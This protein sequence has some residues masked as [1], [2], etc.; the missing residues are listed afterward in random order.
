MTGQDLLPVSVLTGFLGSGK[1]T[2]LSQLL[3][4]AAMK[5]TAVI[6]NEFGEVGL[7]HELIEKS[8][9]DTILLSSGCLCCTIRGDLVTSL[10]DLFLRRVR[11]EVP[12]FK[13]V[14]IE[15]T[16]LADPAPILH[17]LMNDPLVSAR[18]RLDGVV[19][20]VDAVNGAAT[21][22]RQVEAVKQIAVADRILLTKLDV[23]DATLVE[24]LQHRLRSIN[25]GAPIYPIAHGKI[26]PEKIFDAGLYN[27]N[28]KTL[29][30]QQWLQEEAYEN[31]SHSSHNHGHSHELDHTH[32]GRHHHHQLDV[33]RHDDHIIS[34]CLT[35]DQP[36]EWSQLAYWLDM[37]A[38]YRGD[39]LLRV[40]GL[41]NVAGNSRPVVIHGVQ[42]LFHP[43]VE[44][45]EWPSTDRRS[46]IVFI[47]RDIQ[48]ETIEQTLRAIYG[49]STG[50]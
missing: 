28:S 6:I 1:T 36:L 34:F 40:K 15:T 33:N 3:H 17:T 46:R 44:L 32:E 37:L 4:H 8:N 47:T 26:D 48:R 49:A 7:D 24:K 25:P 9:E 5:D 16:G 18:Y 27:P 38:T 14:V 29:D 19:T 39:D 45:Q 50:H 42:H 11:Q 20:T 21:L 23:A 30:V 41:L 22:D 12:E 13:R 43:P 31:Y 2:L 35:I 10:R